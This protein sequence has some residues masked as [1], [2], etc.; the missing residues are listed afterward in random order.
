M[1]SYTIQLAVPSTQADPSGRPSETTLNAPSLPAL[2][3]RLRQE[4]YRLV[5]IV[6][7]GPDRALGCYWRKISE[8]EVIT[9]LRQL[10]VSLENGV[11]L[12]DGLA[13]LARETHNLTL[14]ALA[15]RLERSVR[16]GDS[17]SHGLSAYPRIF[18]PVHVRLLEAGE[19][20]GRMPQVLRQLADYAERAGTAAQRIRTALVY[21]QVVGIF[22]LI[23]MAC[24][25]I[26][27]VPKFV[28][29]FEELGVKEF[30]WVTQGLFWLTTTVVPASFIIVPL[31]LAPASRRA[32]SAGMGSAGWV[33]PR[34]GRRFPTSRA[35][36][37]NFRQGVEK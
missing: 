25:F 11:S 21:P 31:P 7:P 28:R 17:L 10:A 14:R 32:P 12:A 36:N 23:L 24:T 4:G 30:P 15:L 3:D 35:P 6:N 8:A 20:G 26:W 27:V 13:L 18:S 5:R 9:F 16:E 37:P 34:P 29:L 22:T 19:A 2:A 1:P 33:P